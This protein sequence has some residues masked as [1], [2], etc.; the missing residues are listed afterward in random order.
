MI[1][2]QHSW[3]MKCVHRII[4]QEPDDTQTGVDKFSRFEYMGSSEFEFNA[5]PKNMKRFRDHLSDLKCVTMNFEGHEVYVIARPEEL[6]HMPL[7][8]ACSN[9]QE[10]PRYPWTYQGQRPPQGGIAYGT[11]KREPF[12]ILYNKDFAET[13]C[14]ELGLEFTNA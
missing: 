1:N 13:W 9:H 11:Y 8:L 12:V 7:Y 14:D 10:D 4:A 3:E 5:L 2:P 6:E